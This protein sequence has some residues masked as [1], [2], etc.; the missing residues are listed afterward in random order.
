M[1]YTDREVF[2]WCCA[3]GK[4]NKLNWPYCMSVNEYVWVFP[5][6]GLRLDSIL[7]LNT[8]LI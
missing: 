1:Q 5:S 6:T 3:I 8:T 4:L 7:D 2:Y